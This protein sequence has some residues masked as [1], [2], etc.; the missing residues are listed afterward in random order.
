[1]RLLWVRALSNI[2]LRAYPELHQ[3]HGPCDLSQKALLYLL[4]ACGMCR[5]GTGRELLFILHSF[6]EHSGGHAELR[7]AL[8]L[9]AVFSRLGLRAC[10][11]PHRI[12]EFYQQVSMALLV[13]EVDRFRHPFLM[14]FASSSYEEHVRSDH[15]HK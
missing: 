8:L 6:L 15:T 4:R 2:S 9:R 7:L 12:R 14:N 3:H 13:C 10:S 5:A 11:G 1:M